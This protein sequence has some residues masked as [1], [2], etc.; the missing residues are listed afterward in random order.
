MRAEH[1]ALCG[2][3]VLWRD[4]AVRSAG[5]AIDGLDA[6]GGA[7][8]PARLREVARDEAFREAVT[9]Q[10]PAAL[11]NA[12]DRLA[13]GEP[14]KPSR[15]RQREETVASY[16]QRYCAKNDTIGFF[17]PLAWGRIRDDGPPLGLHGGE[18]IRERSVHLEAWGVQALAAKLDP[19]LRVANGHHAERDLRALLEAHEDAGLRERGLAALDR[20]EA[21]HAQLAS[22]TR[23]TLLDALRELDRVFVELTGEQPTRNPGRAYGAR[24][25]AYVDCMRDLDVELGPGLVAEL[26]PVAT[27]VLE[28]GRWYCGQVNEVAR[29]VVEMALE[30][31]GDGPLGPVFGMVLGTLMSLPPQLDA[32]VAELQRRTDALLADPDRATL[33][34]RATAIFAD[35]LPAWPRSGFSS[36]DIQIAARDV[37]A[38]ADG[39]FL[40][41][42]GD[43]HPGDNPLAQGLFGL[44]HPDPQAFLALLARDAGAQPALLLPPW[45]PG[46]GVDARG[47]P[48]T[49]RGDVVILAPGGCAPS[50]TR[51]WSVEELLVEGRDVVDRAGTLRVSLMDV[52]GLPTFVTAVRTFELFAETEHVER[53]TIGR[54]VVRRET[55]TVPAGEVPDGAGDLRAWAQRRGLPRRVFAKSPLERKPMY[56]DFDSP[57]LSRILCRHARRAA[58]EAPAGRMRFS[59]MLPLPEDCWLADADGRRYAGELRLVAVDRSAAGARA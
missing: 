8:E 30:R 59:E 51:G 42:V 36:I 57:V 9:W 15:A 5:F 26:A 38:V 11:A 23:A 3:W 12:L 44:R 10:N 58:A 45:G 28:A 19:S 37:G 46:M 17:G 50:G 49:A 41:I 54:T 16:W 34:E 47:F 18:L 31:I 33:A 25:L 55:W 20:L 7:D 14:A 6:F 21:A 22:A 13:A 40:A 1:V 4:F 53:L 2:D 35:H 24:T 43:V 56:L 32:H 48:L 52:F 39:D 27:A 29:G